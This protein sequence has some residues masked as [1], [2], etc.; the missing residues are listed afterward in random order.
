LVKLLGGVGGPEMVREGIDPFPP[1]VFK[2]P[3]PL[4]DQ[5]AR[6]IHSF[7]L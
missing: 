7:Y 1:E 3:D 5:R 2:F 6:F 4:L